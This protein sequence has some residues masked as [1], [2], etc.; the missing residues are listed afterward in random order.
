MAVTDAKTGDIR[1][2]GVELHPP[3]MWALPVIG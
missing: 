3:V 1:E 2:R